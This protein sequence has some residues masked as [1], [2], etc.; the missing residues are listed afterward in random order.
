[1][2]ALTLIVMMVLL[3]GQTHIQSPPQ[4]IQEMG[5]NAQLCFVRGED[6]GILNIIRAK[7]TLNTHQEI[8]MVGG[9]AGCFC[10]RPGNYSFLIE[11][12]NPYPAADKV[13]KWKSLRYN[14]EL[15]EKDEVLYQLLPR[16]RSGTY[17]GGWLIRR[18]SSRHN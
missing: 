3:A 10:L 6:N 11:S 12:P 14:V 7:V 4:A 8:L 13:R 16:Q 18:I 15:K 1:M 5:L 17:T 9:Q 2:K